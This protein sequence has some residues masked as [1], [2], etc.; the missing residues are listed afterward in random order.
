[1][2][3]KIFNF[4]DSGNMIDERGAFGVLIAHGRFQHAWGVAVRYND[5]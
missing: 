3:C 4:G 5:L 1:M 2:E